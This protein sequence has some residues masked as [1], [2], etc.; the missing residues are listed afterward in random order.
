MAE[1][2]SEIFSQLRRGINGLVGNDL[3]SSA[4]V[5]AH[6]NASAR[7]EVDIVST[8]SAIVNTVSGNGAIDFDSPDLF[9]ALPT[10]AVVAPKLSQTW[11]PAVAKASTIAPGTVKKLGSGKRVAESLEI[12]IN[13][14]Q[15]LP[16]TGK[17]SIAD[18]AKAIGLRN[19]CTIELLPNRTTFV[20]SG[21]PENIKTARREF[22]T[23]VGVYLTETI[24]V[25]SSVR[26]H[27]LGAGGK[28]LK[29]LI[30]RTGTQINVPKAAKPNDD[31]EPVVDLDDE[32]PITIKGNF[33]GVVEAKKE[34][35]DI[36]KKRAQNLSARLTIER[37]YHP[38]IAGSNNST[39]ESIEEKTGTRIH[40]PPLVP[41]TEKKEGVPE[42]NVNEIV[43]VGSREGVKAA[44]EEIRA[45]YETLR[46]QTRTLSFPVKKR[47][48]RFIIGTK[49]KNLQ[50]IL[51]QTGCSV[52]L[53]AASDP[54]D[55]VT[56]RGPDNM[57][58]VA[59]QSVL[60]KSN[61]VSIEEIFVV[62]VL[63]TSV[64]PIFFLKYFFTKEQVL[65]KKIESAHN[66]SI[67]RLQEAPA[68]NPVIEIQGKT[69]SE[70]EAA[71]IE[72]TQL[73]REIGSAL[74]FGDVEIPHGL[75]K[76][77][78]GK[79]GQNIVKMKAQAAWEGRLVDVVVPNEAEK[80]DEVLIVV[81]RLP[82]GLGSVPGVK[83]AVKKPASAEVA[84]DIE[85]LAFVE[86]VRAEILSVSLANEDLT[87]E[88]VKV[89]GKFHGRIIGSR[90][91]D[92]KEL[93][94]T[95]GDEVSIRFP[96]AVTDKKKD[97]DTT[98]EKKNVID[99]NTI[100]I[101]GPKKLVA[102][103]KGKIVKIVAELKRIETLSSFSDTLKVKKGAG[104]KLVQGAGA[105]VS[106]GSNIVNE[107]GFSSDRIGWLIGLVKEALIANPSKSI[108]EGATHEDNHM[109]SLLKIDVAES[110][111]EI[112]DDVM[113][114]TGPKNVVA[115]AKK[116]ISERAVRL[117]NQ[118]TVEFK[119]FQT[120]SNVSKDVLNENAIPDLKTRVIRRLIGKGGKNVNTLMEKF[121]VA[122]QFPEGGKKRRGKGEAENEIEDTADVEDASG[123]ILDGTVVLKGNPKDVESAKHEIMSIV[124]N[125]IVK[126]FIMSFEI[127]RSVL[128]RVLGPSGSKI[129]DL[130]DTHDVRI[131][132]RDLEGDDGEISVMITL[133][134]S[135]SNCLL[136]EKKIRNVA[137][138][139]VNVE[140]RTIQ[141]PSYLHKDV[142]GTGGSRIKAVIDSFGGQD[143]VKIQFP[144]R[145]DSVVGSA[146]SNT[147]S[148]K[149][150]ATQIDALAAAVINI[151][152]D[153]IAG[154]DGYDARLIDES[155]ED[156]VSE[157]VSVPK[158]DV[159][160]IL[161][162]GGDSIKD[163]IRRFNVN[164]WF[165]E[166]TDDEIDMK[167]VG[168]AENSDN[169]HQAV[170]EIKGKLRVSKKIPLPV[171][172]NENLVNDATR[173]TEVA[174]VEDIVKRVRNDSYGT[175]TAE[176]SAASLSGTTEG[177]ITIR[178][179]SKAV[180]NSAKAV[181]KA[182]SELTK[183]DV[184]VRIPI[185][186][187]I[188]GHIIGKA[189]ATISKIRT[190]TKANV[191]ITNGARNSG[192]VVIVRGTADAV[193]KATEFVQKIVAD[194]ASR[195]EVD[196]ARRAAT[197]QA[198][199]VS[200]EVAS[201]SA[202]PARLDDVV[203]DGEPAGVTIG[204]GAGYVPGFAPG[205][206]PAKG[207][208][209][210]VPVTVALTST[211]AP[212]YYASFS[213]APVEDSWKPVG[214][215]GKKDEDVLST[216]DGAS[217]NGSAIPGA[218]PSKK[219]K[220]NKN[221]SA[222][223]A[224]AVEDVIV[225]PVVAA[226]TEVQIRASSPVK[227]ST[228]VRASSPVRVASPV[229]VQSPSKPAIVTREVPLQLTV[230][231][232]KIADPTYPPFVSEAVPVVFT[233][234]TLLD[235]GWTVI[236][237][238]GGNS[239]STVIAADA[240]GTSGEAA[241]KKK[242]NKSKKKKAGVNAA[243]TGV[244]E[245]GDEDEDDADE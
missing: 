151:A 149:A 22:V 13:M 103:A 76:Y 74:F 157:S 146:E 73:I 148:I 163:A 133:E 166:N 200:R 95:F 153:V 63:P 31:S 139:V 225:A 192:D 115:I 102:E 54:S 177:F 91:K 164:Y 142:I 42:K 58:S 46:R 68:S 187:G 207:K 90:G 194:Q 170:E 127:P 33:E 117:A 134:G 105:P 60:Q 27:I 171:K 83:T 4:S 160:R 132:L 122:I 220:R 196:V 96:P 169:V 232:E 241:R 57:L 80:S 75:H 64:N 5:S 143:K 61:Q 244:A 108:E 176:I 183:Y 234:E 191:E 17:N 100:V 21:K 12:P 174:S 130:R 104:R 129:R 124:E 144:N 131:D 199:A 121:N 188:K 245:K 205:Q 3:S 49:G 229:K 210:S 165:I 138:E 235:D 230:V 32:Q 193:E 55:M 212:S 123:E 189:G 113:T 30:A 180:N 239:V 16:V 72:L 10:P 6:G 223:T 7:N 154:T 44:E 203:V 52:E 66:V 198:S 109:L 186:V 84:D 70:A 236:N 167:V 128:P 224:V 195:A 185:G 240:N 24:N 201:F 112:G 71:S 114:F 204:V 81:L 152:N 237:K 226:A 97:D 1:M 69:K 35:E 111:K 140:V 238:R 213:S 48:H 227:A 158:S 175:A 34:I 56:V 222:L 79:G 106:T 11:R 65:I 23:A 82:G 156:V 101:R 120:C 184:T 2:E 125:E 59:L 206:K 85:A 181:E 190:E 172:V 86:K 93:L 136:V 126:S 162:K 202:G 15:K 67:H 173:S 145:G 9:P 243:F 141:I 211:A 94:A 107:V 168:L 43:I 218:G 45:L 231:S 25:P 19:S 50:E 208:K 159:S 88:I 78:V 228:P 51:E 147:I 14:Q 221:N 40:I 209:A 116:I 37:S 47:Q 98:V 92:L 179:E 155:F 20:L 53:P 216:T 77:V 39:V 150:H 137:D 29:D 110:T 197:A 182:L 118:V 242:K 18:H 217:V 89:D 233:S 87:T 36:V 38:F 119:I 135:K 178:G 62:S 28:N 215:K 8:A 26:P 219:K 161:G 214:K 99:P 41:S